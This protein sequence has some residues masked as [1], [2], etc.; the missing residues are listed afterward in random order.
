[1]RQIPIY[2]ICVLALFVGNVYGQTHV[3]SKKAQK[4]ET[5]VTK[6]KRK[7]LRTI[8]LGVINARAIDLV[9]P[10][11]PCAAKAINAY[12]QVQVQ[13]IIDSSGKVISA[14]VKKGYPLLRSA[15]LKAAS[16]ST[17]EP[18]TINEMPVRI[19][20][21]INYNFLPNQWNW[22]E[23]GFSLKGSSSYYSLKNLATQL[24]TGFGDESHFLYQSSNSAESWEQAV[25]TT[26][27]LIRGKLSG[28]PR[29][30]WLFEM[31]LNLAKTKSI[32]CRV[33]D[34]LML[35]INDFRSFLESA[36]PNISAV[37][38]NKIRRLVS[39]FEKLRTGSFNR[40]T[41]NRINKVLIDIED[42]MP[43]IGR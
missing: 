38:F 43:F 18:L 35:S 11:Y 3:T 24:P 30:G 36:P 27:A 41:E 14:D 17:F 6:I 5:P 26:V 20:G 7:Q 31:G 32:C 12:G 29:S 39:L 4:A 8:S 28:Y 34:E 10:T 40:I 19:S 42:K 1:M 16:K 2:F 15:A 37:L 9:K 23:I 33:S 22:L 13:V 21:I 25:E